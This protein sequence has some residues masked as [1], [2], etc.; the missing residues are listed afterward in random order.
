MHI[1]SV[2]FFN[3]TGCSACAAKCPHKAIEMKE[4]NDGFLYPVVV[5][6]KCTNCELCVKICP[7]L[8]VSNE[9]NE[10]KECYAAMASDEI[11][12]LSSSGGVFTVLAEYILSQN[13]Y[14]CCAPFDDNLQLIYKIINNVN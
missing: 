4:N 11:R 13:G 9:E 12:Q 7:A 10:L 14:I 5:E 1:N 3:C 6:D 2:D 8:H